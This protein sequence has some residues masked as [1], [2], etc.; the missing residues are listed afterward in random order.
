MICFELEM[1][2]KYRTSP[3]FLL[4]MKIW[5]RRLSY[6]LIVIVWL[7]VMALPIFAFVLAGRGEMTLGP[8]DASHVR[9]FLVREA[10]GEGVGVAWTRP[11]P[12]HPDCT[13]TTVTYLMWE[14]RSE[15]SRYCQCFDAESGAVS[16]AS[17][18]LCPTP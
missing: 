18:Q 1:L 14:G 8:A 12:D 5:L 6:L 7:V 4:L 9:L 13:R 11:L 2:G 10:D 3:F 17:A 15:N 16:P